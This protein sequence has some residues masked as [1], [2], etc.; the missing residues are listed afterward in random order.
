MSVIVDHDGTNFT[1]Q[2]S[3]VENDRAKAAPDRKWDKNRRLWVMP[4]VAAIARYIDREFTSNEL[5]APATRNINQLLASDNPSDERFPSWFRFKNDPLPHQMECLNRAWGNSEFA[6][7]MWMGRGKTFTVI[8]WAAAAAMSGKIN[9]LVIVCPSGVKS[10]WPPE[11]DKH[12]PIPADVFVMEAGY[13][14]MQ[15]WITETDP[16]KPFKVLIVGIEALSQGSGVDWVERFMLSH[17]CMMAIDESSD[18]KNHKSKRT[19]RCWHLGGLALIRTIM[20]GTEV[21]EG[22]ENL[23]SQYRFLDWQIIGHKSYFTF[24]ARYCQYG[25]F[26]NR[27][28][29][30]YQNFK[31]LMELISPY[32]YS[33]GKDVK[34][35]PPK[36]Y[37]PPIKVKATDAQKKA[38]ADL[39]EYEYTEVDDKELITETILERTMRYQQIAGGFF[40]FDN[41]DGSHGIIPIPGRNPK[42]EALMNLLDDTSRNQQVI[43]WAKFLPEV[44]VIT[45]A[46]RAKY[47]HDTVD[48]FIGGSTTDERIAKVARFQRGETRFMVANKAMSK[49]QTLTA[50]T[51]VI[52][53]SNDFSYDTRIQSEERTHRH[54][55]TN[56]VTYVD[57][58]VDHPIELKILTAISRKKD[59]AELVKEELGAYEH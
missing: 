34:G 30:G 44:H 37:L 53:Y 58:I 1:V 45:E 17:R 5:T 20:T 33:I 57:I 3:F 12:C 8:N 35:L 46:L 40:P 2:C 54:G 11:L 32:T 25:G 6:M 51:L 23:F 10:V 15:R 27:Q 43:I 4:S 16:V 59:M 48:V 7:F 52:Y 26:E 39:K 47:G 19:Q 9:A 36:I 28:I 31:E 22:I 18:I 14:G 29:V 56:T 42:L 21:T 24:T 49:G 38:F 13:H 55:Q 41:E 50:A